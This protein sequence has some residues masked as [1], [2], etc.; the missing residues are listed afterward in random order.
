[1]ARQMGARETSVRGPH[2]DMAGNFVL[3]HMGPTEMR[4]KMAK[5]WDPRSEFPGTG[6]GC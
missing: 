3:G 2:I 4:E 6:A 5:G 1:M